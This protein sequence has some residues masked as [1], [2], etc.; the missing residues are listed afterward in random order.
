MRS[1][2]AKSDTLA[3]VRA[4]VSPA[5][6]ASEPAAIVSSRDFRWQHALVLVA[7]TAFY[8]GSYAFSIAIPD[9][10][11]DIYIARA[12]SVGESFPLEGPVLGDAVH[13]GPVWFYLLAIPLWFRESWLVA[14]L[15]AGAIAGL[16]YLLAYV[17]GSHIVDR[18]FGLLWASALA[19]PGWQTIEQI[20]FTNANVAE[21]CVLASLYCGIRMRQRPRLWRAFMLGIAGGLAFHGHPT[22]LPVIPLSL[23]VAI[24]V[25]PPQRR[26]TAA[27]VFL[28]GCSA[29]FTPYLASQLLHGF[30]DFATGMGYVE[31][32][33]A[34]SQVANAFAIV[35]SAAFDG[36]LLISRYVIGIDEPLL[37]VVKAVL[38]CFVIAMVAAALWAA[39]RA[40]GRPALWFFGAVAIFAA[41]IAYLRPITPVYFAYVLIPALAAVLALGVHA[42]SRGAAGHA[43]VGVFA[44]LAVMLQ[45]LVAWRI[46]AATAQGVGT[47]PDVGNIAT[48]GSSEPSTNVWFPSFAHDDSGLFLCRKGGGAAVHGPLAF[49][50]DLNLGVDSLIRCGR[51]TNVQLSGSADADRAHWVG[52]P[53]SFWSA[54]ALRPRCWIG[55]LGLAEASLKLAPPDAIAPASPKAF[56]P[57]PFL[58][59]PLQQRSISFTAHGRQALVLTNVIPWYMPWR[60][61]SVRANGREVSPLVSTSTAQLYALP[62]APSLDAVKWEAVF[63]AVDTSKIDAVTV[64]SSAGAEGPAPPCVDQG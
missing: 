7:L 50:T 18:R 10:T 51:V 25:S 24:V 58:R 28:A 45:A 47:L 17:C 60:V 40:E 59:G 20:A 32:K 61:L 35:R 12:I 62:G 56:L 30:P 54:A 3:R 46:G 29:P 42:L 23:A 13:G 33:V 64:E 26:A 27:L 48:S 49:L 43:V 44:V 52:M 6:T 9:S 16:K 1:G 53:K 55:P 38:A 11:R 19:L 41:S 21:A 63:A 39:R 14:A 36:P 4:A 8:T 34:L 57:R 15:F 31:T 5:S 22:T 37:W 2:L